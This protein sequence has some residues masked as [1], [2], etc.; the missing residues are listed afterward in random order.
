MQIFETVGDLIEFL[1]KFDRS[2][3]VRGDGTLAY[4]LADGDFRVVESPYENIGDYLEISPRPAPAD[5]TPRWKVKL[6]YFTPS[7]IYYS[8]G[9]YETQHDRA[10]R[11]F[12]EVNVMKIEGRL[13]G[14]A[15]GAR[16]FHILVTFAEDHPNGCPNLFP[17]T[18]VEE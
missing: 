6:T 15:R 14:L 2:M 5:M 17:Y 8:E 7:G 3:K 11:V 4:T 1:S 10:W 9:E 18:E 12:G 13:P 16:E